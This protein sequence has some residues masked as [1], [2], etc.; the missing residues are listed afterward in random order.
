MHHAKRQRIEIEHVLA[1]AKVDS[2]AVGLALL[3]PVYAL[4]PACARLLEDVGRALVLASAGGAGDALEEPVC[5]AGA[6]VQMPPAAAGLQEGVVLLA[7]P[8]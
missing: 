7:W 1:F 5:A 8:G 2:G 6:T 3:A 4:A